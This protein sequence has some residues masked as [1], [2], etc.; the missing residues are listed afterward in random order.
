ML[1]RQI[2]FNMSGGPVVLSVAAG[3][4]PVRAEETDAQKHSET[5]RVGSGTN[6]GP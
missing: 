2:E 4:R 6:G 1:R 5:W 3:R